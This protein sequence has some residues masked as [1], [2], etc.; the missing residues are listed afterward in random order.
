[1]QRAAPSGGGLFGRKP[2]AL[3]DGSSGPHY[4]Q[5]M[6]LC[7]RQTALAT[8]TTIQQPTRVRTQ[9]LLL[10]LQLPQQQ[11]RPPA[12]AVCSAGSLVSLVP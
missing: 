4:A 9:P 5:L 7:N 1:M 12:A 10:I 2:G 3:A 6:H 8:S 11:R